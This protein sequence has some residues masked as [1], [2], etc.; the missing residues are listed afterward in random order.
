MGHITSRNHYENL[1]TRLNRFPQGAPPS[2]TL[3]KLLSVLFSEEEAQ[4]VFLLPVQAFTAKIAS[5]RSKMPVDECESLLDGLAS[6]AILL[7][8]EKGG[9][10]IISCPHLWRVGSSFR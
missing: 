8:W 2:E 6:R 7:D 9:Y 4:F 3:N 1:V 5:K 10:V